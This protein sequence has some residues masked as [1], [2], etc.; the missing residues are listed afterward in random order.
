VQ[1]E[2]NQ[3]KD[4]KILIVEEDETSEKLISITVKKFSKEVIKART[5]NEDVVII[6]QT[7]FGLSC[8]RE[9]AIE[10]GCNDYMAKPIKKDELLS[11]IQKYFK[12]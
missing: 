5:C 10:T 11:L 9:K 2:K 7:A 12:K 3:I 8:D 4:L 1:N 6:A